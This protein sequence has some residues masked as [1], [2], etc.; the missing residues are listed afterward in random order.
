MKYKTPFIKPHFPA[1]ELVAEDYKNIVDSNWFTNFGPF[2]TRFREQAAG[3]ISSESFGVTV[4]NATLG[5]ELAIRALMKPEGNKK[6]VIMPSFTFIAGAEALIS[7]G[8]TPVF[9]DIN[10]TTWQPS[11]DLAREYIVQHKDNIA[12]LLLCNVFGV[13]NPDIKGWEG[14]AKEYELPLI[15]DSAAGFG[16][17]YEDGTKVGSRGDCEI[18][19]FHATKP[20]AVG[21]G[22]LIATKNIALAEKVRE[23]SNFGFNASKEVAYIGTNAK[24]QE[25]N[26]AIGLRQ[27]ENFS[28]RLSNR[29]ESL[30]KY[31][32]L[33]PNFQFQQNDERSTIAFVSVKAS[34]GEQAQRIINSLLENGIEARKY[35]K[36]LHYEN[37]LKKYTKIAS[38]LDVTED[39]YA[40]IISLPLHDDMNQEDIKLIADLVVQQGE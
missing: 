1:P 22:G 39:V 32:S 40:S 38:T 15:V 9:V 8:L 23:M 2:E 11:L 25:L 30:V 7:N 24:L 35:Y 37:E 26:A 21:E 14:L 20:F 27:L 12:G 16:S 28:D 36:P 10:P 3:Y 4:P 29:R 34:S 31:K 5:L 18:F 6:E 13:G 19:S 33:L 17:L